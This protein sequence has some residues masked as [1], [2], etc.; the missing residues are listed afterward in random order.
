MTR[1]QLIAELRAQ[2]YN[3]AVSYTKTKLE[4]ILAQHN[5]DLA[6]YDAFTVRPCTINQMHC[7]CCGSTDYEDIVANADEGYTA[8]C[9]KTVVYSPAECTGH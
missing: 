1:N 2:G 4:A 3:G 7:K 5:R 8:C 6:E 9:N